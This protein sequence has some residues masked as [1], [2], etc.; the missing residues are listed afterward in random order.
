MSPF[1]FGTVDTR[2]RTGLG[3]KESVFFGFLSEWVREGQVR[4]SEIEAVTRDDGGG[5]KKLK[6]GSERV[7]ILVL[8]VVL[9]GIDRTSSTL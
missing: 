1:S 5:R 6:R 2:D 8:R 4:R 7:Q 3:A 9:S